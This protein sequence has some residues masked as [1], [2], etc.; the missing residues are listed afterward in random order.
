MLLVIKGHLMKRGIGVLMIMATTTAL[1]SNPVMISMPTE[2]KAAVLFSKWLKDSSASKQH[3]WKKINMR[4]VHKGLVARFNA[5][6]KP[7]DEDYAL[8]AQLVAGTSESPLPDT[9]VV[10][11]RVAVLYKRLD[12]NIPA[13]IKQLQQS[14][15]KSNGVNAVEHKKHFQAVI[16]KNMKFANVL[17]GGDNEPKNAHYLFSLAQRLFFEVFDTSWKESF[18]LFSQPEQFPVLRFLYTI[19]WNSLAG[20]GWKEW[21]AECLKTLK[22]N[23]DQGK[24]IRYIAGGCDI[25]ELI[26]AGVYNIEIIDPLLPTQPRYYVDNWDWFAGGND[27][28]HAL[29]DSIVFAKGISMVRVKYE[30][31]ATQMITVALPNKTK[32]QVPQSV[33]TWEVRDKKN[34]PLGRVQFSR[35]FCTQDDF[36]PSRK[37][38]L[39][40]S[41]NELH[42]ITCSDDENWGID[43][44]KFSKGVQLHIKQLYKPVSARMAGNLHKAD[45]KEFSF[46]RLGSCVK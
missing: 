33:T 16:D 39:L 32:T 11:K 25:S 43:P 42:F 40:I 46:I 10:Q 7:E 24:V 3:V 35:R 9:P 15:F 4:P 12:D 14:G 17:A 19:I 31:D 34:V 38:E 41:F 5:T 27:E 2:K 45:G 23:A 13:F 8:F 21:S 44:H 26:N 36:K 29:G 30:P 28:A 37:H 22:A 1:C 18:R 6:F 20:T